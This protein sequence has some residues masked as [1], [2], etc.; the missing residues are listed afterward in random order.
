M[1][2]DKDVLIIKRES[3]CVEEY[4]KPLKISTDLHSQV[5]ALADKANQ[6]LS[7]VSCMLIEFALARVRVEE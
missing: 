5:K 2:I 1:P 6:P 4:M 3:Y 7:K